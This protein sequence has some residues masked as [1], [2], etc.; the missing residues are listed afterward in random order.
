[1]NSF[2]TRYDITIEGAEL[3]QALYV[4]NLLRELIQEFCQE[5]ERAKG[6][7]ITVEAGYED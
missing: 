5:A 2:V 1:M 4:A 6:C 7:Q 3:P